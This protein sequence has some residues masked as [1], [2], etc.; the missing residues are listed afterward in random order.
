MIRGKK[1]LQK[2]LHR[3]DI[4]I[5]GAGGSY[6]EGRKFKRALAALDTLEVSEKNISKKAQSTQEASVVNSEPHT[7]ARP[8]VR[9]RVG[10]LNIFGR[11]SQRLQHRF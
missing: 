4:S 1:G 2:C 10:G 6:Y 9:V 8:S 5:H 3:W 11:S 7:G